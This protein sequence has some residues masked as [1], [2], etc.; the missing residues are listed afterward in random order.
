MSNRDEIRS[1]EDRLDVR[2]ELIAQRFDDVKLELSSAAS[3]ATRSWPVIAV[4]GG[5]AAGYAISR[6]VRQRAS[7]QY[8]PVHAAGVE[9]HARA[10]GGLL[11]AI[12]AVAATAIRIGTSH[13]AHVFY[14]AVRRFRDR[15]RRFH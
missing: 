7:V 4:A 5:L 11:A 6:G 13:E 1:L 10:K 12:A 9:S 2:R 14:N 3:K 15:R 8:V